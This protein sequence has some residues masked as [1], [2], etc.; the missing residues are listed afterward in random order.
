MG[1]PASEFWRLTLKEFDII[2][3]SYHKTRTEQMDYDIS[4]EWYNAAFQRQQKLPKLSKLLINKPVQSE[5]DMLK[6]M[7]KVV[8]G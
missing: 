5:E 4:L 8:G 1:I 3:E 6:N 2:C 7:L